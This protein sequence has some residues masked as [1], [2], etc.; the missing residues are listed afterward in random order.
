MPRPRSD[1]DLK[2]LEVPPAYA[3]AKGDLEQ[4]IRHRR[5]SGPAASVADG[6]RRDANMHVQED[7]PDDTARQAATAPA[8]R[9]VRVVSDRRGDER[10][11]IGRSIGVWRA[12]ELR[13]QEATLCR[14]AIA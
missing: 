1:P 11:V 7:L 6:F 5:R 8:A 10:A 4:Q 14:L 13:M 2:R 12:L 3:Q 9:D